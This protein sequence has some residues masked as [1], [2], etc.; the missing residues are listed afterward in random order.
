MYAVTPGGTLFAA[1]LNG[2]EVWRKSYAKDFGGGVPGWGYSE[3]VLVD[4]DA[5]ICTPCSAKAAVVALKA[6]DGEVIWKTEIAKPGGA[7]GYC[8]AVKTTVGKTD[9]YVTLLG[10]DGGVVGVDA[11]T[12]K[13]LWQYNRIMNGTANIPTP[14]VSGD[15]VWCSTGYGDGGAA[16]VHIKESGGKFEPEE[17]K[18][19]D[20]KQLQNHHGG[21]VKVGEY[22]YFGNR[23]NSGL[24]AC[25]DFKTGEVKWKEEKGG[26]G[27]S[28]SGSVVAADGMLYFRY[29]NGKVAL[30]KANPDKF[31]LAGTF[32]IPE[33]SNKPSW[34]HLA[35]AN[36]RLYVRDQDKLHCFDIAAKK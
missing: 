27:G 29:E 34:Q 28:G 26:G 4:G 31:E 6:K 9:M 33:K 25:V 7:G 17:V 11:A 36:G 8:S 14:V 1:D 13:L 2:K 15:M 3:S 16:L 32:D 24:P 30:V 12:G 19:Y 10:K 21:M 20:S 5:V 23:H 22:V 35:I 18:Y